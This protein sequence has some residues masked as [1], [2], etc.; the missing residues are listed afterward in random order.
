MVGN[1]KFDICLSTP[2]LIEYEDVLARE[3]LGIA[4]SAA[5]D[6]LDY[7]CHVA[8]AQEIHYLWRP[9]LKD[10]KD[11]LVL[12]LAVASQSPL[13]ITYNVKDFAGSERFGIRPARPAK[14]LSK[15]GD[16]A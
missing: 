13:I 16:I 8:M 11:D 2:L 10:P 5:E 6:V 14:F 4:K 12:E 1:G 7:L 15:L 9:F 3:A